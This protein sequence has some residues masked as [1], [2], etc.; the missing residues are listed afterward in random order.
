MWQQQAPG[1]HSAAPT[2]ARQPPL[3]LLCREPKQSVAEKH[4]WGGRGGKEASLLGNASV[5]AR[6]D[7]ILGVFLV[8]CLPPCPLLPT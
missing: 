2:D 7:L 1:R 4:V 5:C 6:Q 8:G 3:L